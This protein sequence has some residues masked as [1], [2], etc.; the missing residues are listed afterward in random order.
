M[1]L[2]VTPTGRLSRIRKFRLGRHTLEAAY[3]LVH[4]LLDA[5]LIFA[6][7]VLAFVLHFK[8]GIGPE[9]PYR[10]AP[11]F[12]PVFGAFEVF[13]V[14]VGLATGF[15]RSPAR[16]GAA[17]RGL[18]VVTVSSLA[19]L[20]T[21]AA[22]YFVIPS[23]L[24]FTRE[25]LVFLWLLT[26]ALVFAG[27][28]LLGQAI[29]LLAHFGVGSERIL[30]L[31]AGDGARQVLDTVLKYP[32]PRY[33]VV[34]F[35]EDR[36]GEGADVAA[37][38]GLP[39]LGP[40]NILHGAVVEHDVDK[41]I[42]AIPSLGPERLLEI[43]EVCGSARVALWLLPDHF[44][45]MLSPVGE[46]ELSGLPFMALNEVR[47]KGLSR[48]AK[49]LTD[50][51]LASTLLVLLSGP[52]L[53]AA[54]LIRLTSRG[55]VF[56]AQGRMG[57]DGRLF[58]VL[59]FRTMIPGADRMP[60]NWTV[61]DDPRITSMGRPLRRFS[62]DEL[63]QL[64][65]VILGQ[66]SLVGPRPERPEYVQEFSRRYPRYMERHHEKSGMTGWA[67]VN[68]LRGDVSISE[69]T[70][71]DLYYVENWSLMLDVRILLRTMVEVVR[72]RAY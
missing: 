59:K 40:V 16:V 20:L 29:K 43:A 33:T 51:V 55:P 3:G 37:A 66:M 63:P 50:I 31:G 60:R 42:V 57:H 30:I 6:A 11:F 47:L 7:S 14:A 34:G 64:I 9:T 65:N 22:I 2:S 49:R 18:S 15:Y 1:N 67:Q 44:Q 52:M 12:F 8:L 25:L 71:Y 27:R 46:N 53:I 26:I 70:L 69:R 39:V 62:I 13:F 17:V 56:Y 45:L 38:T 5:L 35:L 4:P 61:A 48:L 23:R 21:L 10:R 19:L 58:P 68:G 24:D 32:G 36:Q 54:L 28:T 72:G 41:V